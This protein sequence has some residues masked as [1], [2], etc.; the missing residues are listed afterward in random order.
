MGIAMMPMAARTTRTVAAGTFVTTAT[1]RAPNVFPSAALWESL[2]ARDLGFGRS[3]SPKRVSTAG[4]RV[5]AARTAGSSTFGD[6]ES[7]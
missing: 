2:T 4:R 3:R 1:Q 6:S 5:S 7:V